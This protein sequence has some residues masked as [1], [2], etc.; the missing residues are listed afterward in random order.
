MFGLSSFPI[1]LTKENEVTTHLYK[2]SFGG[3]LSAYFDTGMIAY[4]LE[5]R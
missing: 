2:V 4:V 5:Y 3:F 1:L